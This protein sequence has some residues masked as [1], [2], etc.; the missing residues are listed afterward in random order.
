MLSPRDSERGRLLERFVRAR[1]TRM[2]RIDVGLFDFD[3]HHSIYF[4]I[5][6]P[7]EQI[8]LRYGGRDAASAD[9]YLDLDSFALALRAGLE[10]HERWRAGELP[11][12]P[13]PP[14][15]F[16]RELERL[17]VQELE[18]GRCV[19]CHMIGDY[20][21]AARER[22]GTLDKRREMF[23]SPDIRDL[24]IHLDV[25]RG[26]AVERAQGAAM[27]AGLLPGDAIVNF[28]GQRVLTFGDL[29]YVYDSLDRAATRLPLTVERAGAG[30]VE[31]VIELPPQWWVSDIAYR[32]W[33]IDPQTHLTAAPLTEARKRDLGFD[34][35]GFACEV[36]R[37][38]ARAGV[39]DLHD[40]RAGDV[41]YSVDGVEA[42]PSVGD[43]LVYLRLN[44]TA[45]EEVDLGVLRDGDRTEVTV[46]T[47]RQRF[48]KLGT[49]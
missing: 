27:V 44:V 45:G 8:Y 31:L 38:N 5:V 22:E 1:I 24:G 18:R 40:L 14:P 2:N 43:C 34:P 7:D 13:R 36:T 17:R 46:R 48:R 33:S 11:A 10:E 41:I 21:A 28:A 3:W 23:R 9:S 19:E 6:S 20:R 25:P 26:L 30:R 4:F 16:A 15:F 49:P 37:V 47:H 42:D 32:Y 39:L 29:L 35:E 12:R